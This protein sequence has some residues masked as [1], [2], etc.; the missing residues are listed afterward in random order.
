[1]TKNTAPVRS[2]SSAQGT[3][4]GRKRARKI[5]ADYLHNA[6]LYYLERYAATSGRLHRV[7][8]DKVRRSVRDHSEQDLGALLPLVDAEITRLKAV[9]LL[10]DD[11]L[12]ALLV[13]GYRARGLSTRAIVQKLQLKEFSR[14][15][16]HQLTVDDVSADITRENEVEAATR[17]LMRRKLWPYLREKTDDRVILAKAKQKS[18]AALARQGYDPDV[19]GT[20]LKSPLLSDANLEE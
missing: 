20:A 12:G 16:I 2:P 7:L 15:L 6:A 10:Q 8:S 13:E 5:T 3:P 1:M 19:I 18:W 17:Y 14:D 11:R 4:R 9:D